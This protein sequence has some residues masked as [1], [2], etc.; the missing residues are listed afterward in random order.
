MGDH[1]D[2]TLKV[3]AGMLPFHHLI[4]ENVQETTL[5]FYRSRV[6][7]LSADPVNAGCY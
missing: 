2:T 4:P 6:T 5:L 1:I 7:R 3:K